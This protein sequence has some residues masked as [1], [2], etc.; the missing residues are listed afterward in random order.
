VAAGATGDAHAGVT[1]GNPHDLDATDVGAAPASHVGVGGGEHAVATASVAGFMAAVDKAALDGHIG[2]GGTAHTTATGVLAGFLS[3]SDKTKLDS[4]AAG[5]GA[6]TVLYPAGGSLVSQLASM[7]PGDRYWLAPGAWSLGGELD[8][9]VSDVVVAGPRDAVLDMGAGD[10]IRVSAG[11]S[12]VQG[13]TVKLTGEGHFHCMVSIDG[14]DCFARGLYLYSDPSTVHRRTAIRVLGSRFDV[15]ENEIVGIG[16]QSQ[17]DV[18]NALVFE[19]IPAS[20]YTGTNDEGLGNKT[21][22]ND[23]VA[24]SFVAKDA[25][26]IKKV[27]IHI[28]GGMSSAINVRVGIQTDASDEP[29]GT[30]LDY[31]DRPW[32]DLLNGN[33]K[34]FTLPSGASV[35]RD[36]RY[37]VVV[38]CLADPG[39]GNYKSPKGHDV[40]VFPDGRY[41]YHRSGSSWF[42]SSLLADMNLFLEYD[43]QA[44]GP[45]GKIAGNIIDIGDDAT[46]AHYV[47]GIAKAASASDLAKG[48][49]VER[50]Q[51]DLGSENYRVA[52][53]PASGWI[54]A[55]NRF[56]EENGSTNDRAYGV[57]VS[58][59]RLPYY[60]SSV[61]V[62]LNSFQGAWA[63]GTCVYMASTDYSVNAFNDMQGGSPRYKSWANDSNFHLFE[64]VTAVMEVKW[65]GDGTNDRLLSIS[66]HGVSTYHFILVFPDEDLDYAT[67]HCALAWD[68]WGAHG[69]WTSGGHHYTGTYADPY[70]QG[71]AYSQ[72]KLG[73]NGASSSG[74]NYSGR[75]YKAL[76]ISLSGIGS[77][78]I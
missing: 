17:V 69:F 9:N 58:T 48:C 67:P 29:S 38:E 28:E 77:K 60:A 57:W 76:V 20:H 16:R 75:K 11:H 70:W 59:S 4:L 31:V 26:S 1:T 14:D 8:L 71:R 74:T 66:D 42:T 40:D 45:G 22:F 50:N 64:T 73:S 72:L 53:H 62:C 35:S 23:K 7:S 27:W 6:W 47:H 15:S 10:Y 41:L 54:I 32:S 2:A 12:G 63:D 68:F 65:T 43:G 46:L 24:M 33:W 3:P 52:I 21:E 34:D 39:L 44:P 36:T 19:A 49:I 30:W 51:F 56:Y 61:I 18:G 55:L 13:F 5:V 37:W 25:G 78:V